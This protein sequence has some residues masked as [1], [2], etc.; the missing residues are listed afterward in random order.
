MR[1]DLNGTCLGRIVQSKLTI[2][3]PAQ[4]GIQN[5]DARHAW[6]PACAGMTVFLA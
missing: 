2:V 3:I 6:I 1:S 5:N 4:A